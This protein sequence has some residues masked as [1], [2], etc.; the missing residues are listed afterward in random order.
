[1]KEIPLTVNELEPAPG[2]VKSWSVEEPAGGR[3]QVLLRD[4]EGDGS[5][6]KFDCNCETSEGGRECPH[7]EAVKVHLME[8]GGF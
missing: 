8:T 7:V 6:F 2:S 3:Y 5:G 1:M 4:T